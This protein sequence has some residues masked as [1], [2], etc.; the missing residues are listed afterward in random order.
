ML[1]DSAMIEDSTSEQHPP[2]HFSLSEDDSTS[3]PSS[4]KFN[5]IPPNAVSH[6]ILVLLHIKLGV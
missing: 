4:I 5:F 3:L 6:S 2:G 1:E